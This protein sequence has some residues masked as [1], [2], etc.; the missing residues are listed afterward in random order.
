M[1]VMM[2]R[3]VVSVLLHTETD[4]NGRK[5]GISRRSGKKFLAWVVGGQGQLVGSSEKRLFFSWPNT[6]FIQASKCKIQGLF[7]DF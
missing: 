5:T 1:I 7:K 2:A 6:G 4:Q 3:A